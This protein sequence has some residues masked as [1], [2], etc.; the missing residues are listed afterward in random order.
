MTANGQRPDHDARRSRASRRV[1]RDLVLA[2]GLLCVLVCVQLI[3]LM[4]G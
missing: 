1:R 4:L 2:A 3:R